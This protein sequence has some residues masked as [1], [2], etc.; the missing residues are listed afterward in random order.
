ML[1]ESLFIANMMRRH[2]KTIWPCW[3]WRVQF[4]MTHILVK[5]FTSFTT[6]Q[7]TGTNE[8]NEDA[9]RMTKFTLS[10]VSFAIHS[11]DL[12]ALRRCWFYWPHGYRNWM[13][14]FKIWRRCAINSPRSSSKLKR[15]IHQLILKKKRNRCAIFLVPTHI[16]FMFDDNVMLQLSINMHSMTNWFEYQSSG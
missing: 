2:S 11:P 1:S 5:T 12:H 10:F 3:K 7:N 9:H 14:T 4:I 16:Q 13:G 15:H 6:E 8:I